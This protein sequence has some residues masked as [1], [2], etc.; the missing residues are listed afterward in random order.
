[1][2]DIDEAS[3]GGH[4]EASQRPAAGVKRQQFARLLVMP[5]RRH[6]PGVL[7]VEV[8]LLRLG[9]RRLVPRMPLIDRIAERIGLDE[10]LAALPVLV[11]GAAEQD[12]NAEVDVD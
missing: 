11:K 5:A 2:S 3:Q 1:M 4:P 12:A 8:A 7:A 10:G 9:K 6:H